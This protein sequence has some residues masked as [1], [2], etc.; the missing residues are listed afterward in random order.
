MQSKDSSHEL[1][2]VVVVPRDPRN[3]KVLQKL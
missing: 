1:E 2:N 3:E